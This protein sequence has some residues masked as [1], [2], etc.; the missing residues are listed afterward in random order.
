MKLNGVPTIVYKVMRGDFFTKVAVGLDCV[1]KR[2][3]KFR[4]IVHHR[5][6]L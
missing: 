3:V 4:D 6:V 2:C 1:I 5:C